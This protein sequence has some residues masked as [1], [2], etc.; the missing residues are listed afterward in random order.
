M[1]IFKKLQAELRRMRSEGATNEELGRRAGVSHAHI[2]RLLN[3]DS[4][5]FEKLS[6]GTALRLF[7]DLARLLEDS[8]RITQTVTNVRDSKISQT[9]TTSPGL[10]S[11]ADS[12]L[13]A[14]G[15][16]DSCRVRVLRLIRE[17][18]K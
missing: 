15:L 13:C 9:A 2:N 10:S 18:A 5:K 16:C 7:P 11:L 6:L 3:G 14:D 1:D 4:E 8:G 12:V 17:A